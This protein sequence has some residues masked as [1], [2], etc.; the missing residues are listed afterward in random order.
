MLYRHHSG[1]IILGNSGAP[2]SLISLLAGIQNIIFALGCV[3]LY[4]TIERVGRRSVLLYGAITMT[5]LVVIFII[6]LAIPS[7]PSIQWGSI[8]VLWVFLFIM[9]YAWEGAVWLYCCEIAPLEYRHIGGAATSTG[10]WLATF[11]TV[12]VGPIGF[13]NCGWRFWIW[14]LSGNLVAIAFV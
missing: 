7:T 12:F 1:S 13:D 4:F 3:P 9:G 11:L 14:V 6:L 2:P 5:T 10:E 8:G